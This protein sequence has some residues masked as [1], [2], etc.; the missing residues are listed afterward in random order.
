MLGAKSDR[1]LGARFLFFFHDGQVSPV[2]D[3]LEDQIDIVTRNMQHPQGRR[4]QAQARFNCFR[5]GMGRA[6]V[7]QLS[8][9][10]EVACPRD[11]RNLGA[12][13]AQCGDGA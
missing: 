3:A 9:C 2:T 1:L 5:I 12:S 10:F 11:D 7:K 13:T 4:P 8:A 6:G